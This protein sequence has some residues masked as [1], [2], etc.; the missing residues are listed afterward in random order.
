MIVI[1]IIGLVYT[2]ALSRLSSVSEEKMTPNFLNLKEYLGTFLKDDAKSVR[3]LCLDDC[4]ECG[5]YVDGERVEKIESFF[6][7]SV[8]LYRYDFLLG[9]MPVKDAV[10]FNEENVQESVC[11]SLNLYA[12]GVTEQLFVLYDEKVY[13]YTS[14]FECTR[15]YDSLS[16]LVEEK[17]TLAQRLM[18]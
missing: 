1:V 16:A 10:Y 7:A 15:A 9:A 17:Q 18:R 14:Y 8:E 4:S 2:L 11:F 3:L 6:D 13:D 5:I 12:N